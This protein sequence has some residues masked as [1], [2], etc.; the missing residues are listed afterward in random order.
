MDRVEAFSARDAEGELERCHPAVRKLP[1]IRELVR[2]RRRRRIA[3]DRDPIYDLERLPVVFPLWTDDADVIPGSFERRRLKPD[4]P[5]E[6][7]RQVLDDYEDSLVLFHGRLR[8]NVGAE[9]CIQFSYQAIP[10]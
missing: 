4:T 9:T 6:W 3:V 5:V 1:R 10:M 7:D 2:R 8:R